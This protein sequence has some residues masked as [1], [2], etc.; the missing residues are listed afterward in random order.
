MDFSRFNNLNNVYVWDEEAKVREKLID[1]L[2]WE[3]SQDE[4]E[5][6]KDYEERADYFVKYD[7]VFESEESFRNFC[8]EEGE[9]LGSILKDSDVFEIYE[10]DFSQSELS[11]KHTDILL[12]L[13]VWGYDDLK[14]FFQI[15]FLAETY[16]D[17][18]NG[19]ISTKEKNLASRRKRRKAIVEEQKQK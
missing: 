19:F 15:P 4:D 18:I 1:N 2:K 17:A 7:N 12:P 14:R 3:T 6:Q 13:R 16:A 8:I 9:V 5:S 11:L 10:E